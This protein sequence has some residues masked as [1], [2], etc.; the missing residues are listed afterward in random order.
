MIDI[1]NKTFDIILGEM[2]ARVSPDL[3]KRDGSLIKTS[4]AAAAWTIE[5]LYL[6][7]AW[8]QRQAYGETA[9]TD[10]LDMIVAECGLERKPAVATVRYARFNIA[11][12]LGTSFTVRGVSDS[13]YFVLTKDAVYSP[14]SEYEDAPYLGEVTCQ[15]AGTV[16]NGYSG[17]LSTVN[18]VPGLIAAVMLGI[19]TVGEDV[20]TDSSLRERYKLAV[21]A[22]QFGG[23][24]AAYKT[25]MLAQSGVGAVQI[26]PV[27]DGPGTVKI[28]AISGDYEPLTPEQ[29]AVLQN[30]VCPPESGGIAPSDKGYGMAPIGAVV[31]VTTANA[32]SV[33]VTA[34]IVI[35]AGSSRTVAEIQADAEVQIDAY[36]NGLCANWGTMASWNSAMYTIK[37]YLNRFVA[38]LNDLDGV[39]VANNVQLNGAASD[40]T[41][42]NTAQEQNVPHIGTV[43][44]TEDS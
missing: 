7:L 29:V 5:G 32:F 33:D 35:S 4:L 1:D 27:W 30:A 14:D 2:L 6:D 42:T 31:T 19:I 10:N 12:P 17:D 37:L 24:I 26:Y 22:V 9:S 3:N 8:V 41:L 25:F 11:P 21:G 34:D 20:E 16:G 36:L 13:P 23:N 28:S 43:T 18:F 15:T 38:I 40:I 44:L 39:E